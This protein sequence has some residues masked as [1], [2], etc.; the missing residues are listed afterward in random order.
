MVY[1]RRISR[2][3]RLV[4]ID[5]TKN[6]VQFVQNVP[7]NTVGV[8]VLAQGTQPANIDETNAA[9]AIY[10]EDGAMLKSITI[11]YRLL[12][13]FQGAPGAPG[14]FVPDSAVIVVRKNERAANLGAPTV[15]QMNQLFA[16]SWK[17][18]IFHCEQAM[19]GQ[20]NGI[21]MVGIRVIIPRRFRTM[22][23][24]DKW[25]LVISNVPNGYTGSMTCCGIAIY[26]WYK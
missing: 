17:N 15:G 20:I 10:V 19:P 13:N 16:Q 11:M 24:G 7:S 23:Q 1:R 8:I 6:I 9:N 2:K 5:S 22:A 14:N 4:P 25:E 21:P 12:S 18:R 26:K 3:M